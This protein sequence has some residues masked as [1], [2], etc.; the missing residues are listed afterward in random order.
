MDKTYWD[1]Q[2]PIENDMKIVLGDVQNG[3]IAFW[4]SPYSLPYGEI[5]I[6][7]PPKSKSIAYRVDPLVC[8]L[9]NSSYTCYSPFCEFKMDKT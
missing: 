9:S 4:V 6:L 8:N 2:F 7:D 1:C 3:M 5:R